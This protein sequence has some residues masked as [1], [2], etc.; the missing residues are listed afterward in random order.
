L[1]RS[2]NNICHRNGTVPSPFI[3]SG[4]D[5]A[6]RNTKVFSVAI[7]RQQWDLF[8]LLSSYKLLQTAVKN[9]KDYTLWTCLC[10]LALVIPHANPIFLRRYYIVVCDLSGCAIFSLI[11]NIKHTFLKKFIEYKNVF[12]FSLQLCLKQ[13]SLQSK[14]NKIS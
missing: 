13:I 3:V 12:W 10:I 7:I 9:N 4:V 11:F 14:I 2:R 1:T 8:A 6:V 5:A